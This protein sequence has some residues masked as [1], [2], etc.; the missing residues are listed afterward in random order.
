MDPNIYKAPQSDLETEDKDPVSLIKAIGLGLLTDLGGTLI[1]SIAVGLMWA[2]N[3]SNADPEQL[4]RVLTTPGSEP[5]NAMLVLGLLMTLLG[6]Y[7]C[8][9]VARR[10]SYVAPAIQGLI[11]LAF[12]AMGPSSTPVGLLLFM[13]IATVLA[14]MGGAWLRIRRIQPRTPPRT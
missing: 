9:S 14:V 7:V 13:N 2:A 4:N 10:R 1:A 6:G 12:G 3:N 5:F 11:L 8:A